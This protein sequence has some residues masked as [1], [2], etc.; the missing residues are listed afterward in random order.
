MKLR[1]KKGE[2]E[3]EHGIGNFHAVFKPGKVVE[4]EDENFAN[5][6]L[7]QGNVEEVDASA[8]TPAKSVQKT[9][10]KR[11]TKKA[12]VAKTQT[13]AKTDTPTDATVP[14][15]GTKETE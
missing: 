2:S 9:T 1:L 11:S 14:S 6:C 13:E 3:A 8:Q 10:N 4:I 5:F 15:D 7:S 12:T